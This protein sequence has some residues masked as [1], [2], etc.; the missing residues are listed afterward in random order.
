MFKQ[1][2]SPVLKL[3][4]L[5]VEVS[6]LMELARPLNH[7]CIHAV[8]HLNIC[9]PIL[10]FLSIQIIFSSKMCIIRGDKRIVKIRG[11]HLGAHSPNGTSLESY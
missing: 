11:G 3:V 1:Y 5:L 4:D 6:A 10:T 8:T 2:L 9:K 7:F